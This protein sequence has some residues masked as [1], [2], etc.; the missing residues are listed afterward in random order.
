[1]QTTHHPTLVHDCLFR[2]NDNQGST[3]GWNG[4][5]ACSSLFLVKI[6]KTTK[7]RF[8]P[9]ACEISC[10]TNRWVTRSPGL[11]N[12]G[13]PHHSRGPKIMKESR[14]FPKNWGLFIIDV[15]FLYGIYVCVCL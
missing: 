8:S 14:P 3:S 6:D 10:A 9:D 13:S 4:V 7:L 1:M 12:V 15:G 11:H 2:E 5:V